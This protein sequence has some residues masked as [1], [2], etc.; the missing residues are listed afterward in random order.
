MGSPRA[1]GRPRVAAGVAV[2][3]AETR[4]AAAAQAEDH[5]TAAPTALLCPQHRSSCQVIGNAA[6][7]RDER[8][9]IERIL[10]APHFIG[11]G[12]NAC[13]RTRIEAR[14]ETVTSVLHLQMRGKRRRR[15]STLYCLSSWELEAH[16]GA[17]AA[18]L[19]RGRRTP[20]RIPD[21]CNRPG[22]LR[23]RAAGENA[24]AF[25]SSKLK[26]RMTWQSCRTSS[27]HCARVF[28]HRMHATRDDT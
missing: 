3:V 12:G 11:V 9:C 8:F 2:G 21:R 28:H 14:S 4:L 19:G 25:R 16:A 15:I 5:G 23:E 26:M 1:T 27:K 7:A 20:P 13:P 24:D 6:A 18:N 10:N 17:R 22:S